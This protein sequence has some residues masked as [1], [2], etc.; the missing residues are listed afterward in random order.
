MD[1]ATGRM[2]IYTRRLAVVWKVENVDHIFGFLLLDDI[3]ALLRHLLQRRT[4]PGMVLLPPY[5]FELRIG[6]RDW[7]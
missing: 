1:S 2:R 6:V 5:T 4:Q 7:I 3:P